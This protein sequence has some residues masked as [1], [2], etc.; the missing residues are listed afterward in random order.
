[1]IKNGTAFKIV[2][3]LNMSDNSQYPFKVLKV[4]WPR[5]INL[6]KSVFMSSGMRRM[7]GGKLLYKD[8]ASAV[9]STFPNS[10]AV[11]KQTEA[12]EQI[13]EPVSLKNERDQT[14]T[15]TP[16]EVKAL[17]TAQ[18]IAKKYEENPENDAKKEKEILKT[19]FD[20][21]SSSK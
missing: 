15:T 3:D 11:A 19:I 18:E 17:E 2:N 21:L 4:S 5:N 16:T 13:L 20:E 8:R 12:I 10:E 1:M 7:V 14:V 6:R 9:Y